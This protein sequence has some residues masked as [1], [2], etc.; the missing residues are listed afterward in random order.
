MEHD[1]K[2]CRGQGKGS[3]FIDR[4]NQKEIKLKNTL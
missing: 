4:E 2:K 3:K 1:K